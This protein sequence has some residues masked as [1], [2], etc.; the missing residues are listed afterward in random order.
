MASARCVVHRRLCRHAIDVA[1]EQQVQHV[2]LRGEARCGGSPQM[3]MVYDA[4][5]RTVKTIS[6]YTAQGTSDPAA[7]LWDDADSRWERADGT[8]IAHGT[9]KDGNRISETTYNKAGQVTASR[10]ARGTRTTFSYDAAGRRLT[11]ARPLPRASA[12]PMAATTHS[13]NAGFPPMNLMQLNF[14]LA[15]GLI[16]SINYQT[17]P[18]QPMRHKSRPS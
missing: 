1:E 7:W 8:A 13:T 2:A 9:A 16:H 6:S 10:D 14:L 17:R 11:T 5:G 4:L 15:N 18:S 3:R 12:S